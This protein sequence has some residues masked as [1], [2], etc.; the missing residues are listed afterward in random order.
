MAFMAA[1]CEREAFDAED[2]VQLRLSTDSIL[3][4]TVI[5]ARS[6]ITQSFKIYNPA[7]RAILID[8]IK[9]ENDEGQT[10]RINVDGAPGNVFDYRIGAQDS[11]FVFVEATINP[12]DQTQPFVIEGKVVVNNG[13]HSDD[14][15]LEA[16]GQNAI[17]HVNDTI[18]EDTRW[19]SSIPHLIYGPCWVDP[20]AR[21]LIDPGARIYFHAFSFLAVLGNLQVQGTPEERVVMRHDR[22]EA[23]YEDQTGQ[24]QG[25]F[26]LSP[27][28]ANRIEYADIRN[29]VIGLRVDSLGRGPEPKLRIR[30]T[31]ITNVES[32]ALVAFTGEIDAVNCEFSNGCEGAF[33]ADLGGQYRFRHVTFANY[34]RNCGGDGPAVRMLE[35]NFSVPEAGIDQPFDLLGAFTNCVID[36]PRA[37]EIRIEAQGGGRLDVRFDHCA[38]RTS[39]PEALQTVSCLFNRD[40]LFV[41]RRD[42]DF[43]P[44]SL[45]PLRDAGRP[46]EVATDLEGTM[47]DL[48]QPDI[49]AYELP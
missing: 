37:D 39:E 21:L 23:F 28:D 13:V 30:N 45:S 2:N 7:D 35:R 12:D 19:G 29:S 17:Y 33:V 14:I 34:P 8:N 24:W 27:S 5:T 22:F 1:A 38:L 25:V 48:R 47:R 41:N 49:G 31:R 46:L 20:G 4:D 9:L 6:T 44:D 32:A 16:W 10:Y 40:T 43:Q 42:A 3:F 15:A 11:L 36:G 26:L 18:E